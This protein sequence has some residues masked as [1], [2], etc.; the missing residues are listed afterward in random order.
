MLFSVTEAVDS[1]AKFRG[2][3]TSFRAKLIGIDDVPE[4]R[5]DRMCQDSILKLKVL[6]DNKFKYKV[7][8]RKLYLDDD[9]FYQPYLFQI[10]ISL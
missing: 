7:E 1:C 2:T 8:A 6:R 5:G 4:S 3:G 9:I 10:K